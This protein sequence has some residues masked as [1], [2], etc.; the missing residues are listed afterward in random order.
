MDGFGSPVK[1]H[2]PR[3]HW[4]FRAPTSPWG[5]LFVPSRSTPLTWTS[6]DALPTV[7]PVGA[8]VTGEIVIDP[9]LERRRAVTGCTAPDARRHHISRPFRLT[10]WSRPA[11]FG[12]RTTRRRTRGFVQRFRGWT[13]S[14]RPG[15]RR[16]RPGAS[17]ACTTRPRE[18][19]L[20]RSF[21]AFP[22]A[23]SPA[24]P[25]PRASIQRVA[26]RSIG[27]APC[28]SPDPRR[29]RSS[30]GGAPACVRHPQV[31]FW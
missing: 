25:S 9:R 2:E 23:P 5:W 29:P 20:R 10:Q 15:G 27:P 11:S 28:R 6:R 3:S 18:R 17:A 8:A 21:V 19:T 7:G 14:P 22:G 26:R 16:R 1:L 13:P 4:A 12:P 30:P 24:P 31:A